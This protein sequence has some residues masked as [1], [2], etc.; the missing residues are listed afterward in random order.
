[1]S[2]TAQALG[3]LRNLEKLFVPTGDGIH[4]V[5]KLIVR[6]CLQLPC[7]RVLVFAETLDDDSVLEIGECRR[8]SH[9]QKPAESL[10]LPAASVY[11]DNCSP[12]FLM[13]SF[14]LLPLVPFRRLWFILVR[15]G[16]ATAS[17]G[18]CRSI[19]PVVLFSQC[20]ELN[21]MPHSLGQCSTP[22]PSSVKAV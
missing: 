17:S 13:S 6:Q 5:A 15:L 4:Q 14:L 16:K 3:S 20:W 1:V 18:S 10:E 11:K 22:A 7:L 8:G 19:Q 21:P 2:P 12:Y 9:V